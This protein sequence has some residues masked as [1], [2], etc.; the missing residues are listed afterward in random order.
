MSSGKSF[1]PR[2]YMPWLFVVMVLVVVGLNLVLYRYIPISFVIAA[3]DSPALELESLS[4]STLELEIVADASVTETG[5]LVQAQTKLPSG[6]ITKVWLSASDELY[7][8]ERVQV[9]G[10]FSANSSEDEWGRSNTARGIVGRIKIVRLLKRSDPQGLRAVLV[11][12]RTRALEQIKPEQ[13]EARALLAGVIASRRTELKAAGTEDAFARTGLSHLI[14]VSGSHLVVVAT[15]I[16]GILAA[17]GFASKSRTIGSLLLST[18]YVLFCASPASAVRSLMMLVVSRLSVFAG[19]R[20]HNLSA[21]GVA[22]LAM[23]LFDPTCAADLGFQLSV[24]SV[25][26]LALFSNYSTALAALLFERTTALY[27]PVLSRIA[28]RFSK[29]LRYVGQTLLASLIC[30]AATL[31]ACG[32]TF[33]QLSLIAP[34]ANV[35]AGPLFGPM[36][37]LG[38]IGCVLSAVPFVG[39]FFVAIAAFLAHLAIVLVRALSA[40]PF[41]SIPVAFP[42]ASEL[43]PLLVGAVLYCLWPHPSKQQLRRTALVALSALV[44]YVLATTIFVPAQVVVLDVGQGDAILVRE[45]IHSLLIDTGPAGALAEALARQH[46]WCLDGVVL[47][48]L[49]DDHT[50]GVEELGNNYRVNNVLVAEGV[51]SALNIELKDDI[52]ALGATLTEIKQGSTLTLGSFTLTCLWPQGETTGQENE[53]SICFLLQTKSF[54]ML[55]TGDA[56]SDVL[57]NI[58]AEA[59]DIDIL[60]VGH[61]GSALSITQDEAQVLKPEVAIASAGKDNSYGHPTLE[62]QSTLKAA[63][64]AF[65]CTID[66]GDITIY[67]TEPIRLA[68]TR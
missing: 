27:I 51:S 5:Y 44:S 23:C 61:H 20:S 35:V 28:R 37:S 25:S 17:V 30:Q 34:V 47:T 13:S 10:R 15:L 11:H 22:G 12:M 9:V 24:L 49:H 7:L 19:R 31:C 63:D 58:A 45:G 41:A 18:L 32:H 21:L 29:Q 46:V 1:P 3:Q 57:A 48:H 8:G 42:Y 38:L 43:L 16:E 33:G 40:L 67:P 64:A 39:Q 60:K 66:H 6:Q 2:P 68:F 62:C 53:D 65:L 50:G 36:V 59:G 54:T 4:I 14:A 26:A 55:L 56:E 52:S